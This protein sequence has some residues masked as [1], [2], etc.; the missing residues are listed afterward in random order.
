ML[1]D[2]KGSYLEI[3]LI[4]PELISD[5][6]SW[7]SFAWYGAYQALQHNEGAVLMKWGEKSYALFLEPGR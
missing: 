7:K 4:V 6:E 5:S 1:A 2:T 3:D